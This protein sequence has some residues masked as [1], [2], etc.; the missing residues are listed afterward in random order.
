LDGRGLERGLGVFLRG[1][2]LGDEGAL[3]GEGGLDVG[4]SQSAGGEGRG[5]LRDEFVQG[6]NRALNLVGW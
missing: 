2:F 3:G 6:I 5:V 1:V 4:R